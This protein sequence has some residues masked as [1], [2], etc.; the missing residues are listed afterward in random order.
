MPIDVIGRTFIIGLGIG[1]IFALIAMGLNL[2]WGTMRLLNVAHGDLIML[3]AYTGYWLFIL[4]EI[5]PFRSAFIAA[6]VCAGIGLI[7]YKILFAKSLRK[8]ASLETLEA[9]SLLIFF[10]FGMIIESV[11]SLLWGANVRAYSYLTNNVRLISISIGL[12]RLLSAL[13]AI[14]GCLL[15]Y[16]YLQKSFFGKAVR[17]VIQ[18]K[19]AAE[20]MGIDTRKIYIFCFMTA[21]GLAGFTG[22]LLS[23]L[24]AFTPFSGFSYTIYAF[25]VIILGGLGNLLGTLIGGLI[26]GLIITFG[27]SLTTPGYGFIIM[28]LMFILVILLMPA[29]ILGK[30]IR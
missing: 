29:G 23:M 21:F 22:G 2:L 8:V 1:C 9:N 26:L 6:L 4:Y 24:Y 13:I 10:G 28:Y 11:V 15:L 27:V 12:N 5:S 3:G 17:A 25:I 18:D 20:L 7:V 14:V 30:A 19:D 16:T